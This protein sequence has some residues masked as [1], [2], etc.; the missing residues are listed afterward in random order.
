[1]HC[2]AFTTKQFCIKVLIIS[3]DKNILSRASIRDLQRSYH[4]AMK[5]LF[6]SNKLFVYEYNPKM[7]L[8]TAQPR[9][10]CCSRPQ[11]LST[12][13]S[14]GRP[15]AALWSAQWISMQP[16]HPLSP[17]ALRGPRGRCRRVPLEKQCP[18]SASRAATSD[19]L[20]GRR[21]T[22]GRT[23]GRIGHHFPTSSPGDRP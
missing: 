4:S 11:F 7:A 12:E 14:P 3:F 1:M 5:I 19:L 22:H 8:R 15:S 9:S 21:Q 17:P 6:L 10:R 13:H 18:A 23:P 20:H 16:H 2:A